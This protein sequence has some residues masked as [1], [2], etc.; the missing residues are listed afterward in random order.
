M[1]MPDD[2]KGVK[3]RWTSKQRHVKSGPLTLENDF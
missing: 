2:A 3:N 1:T